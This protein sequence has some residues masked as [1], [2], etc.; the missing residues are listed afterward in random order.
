MQREDI[1]DFLSAKKVK[2]LYLIRKNSYTEVIKIYDKN[3]SCIHEIIKKR[4][5]C[6]GFA[7]TPQTAK[8][9]AIIYVRA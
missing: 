1:K 2:I 7:V 6:F 9:T 8:D 3:E 4:N 5:A